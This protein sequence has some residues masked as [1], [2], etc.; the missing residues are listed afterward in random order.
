MEEINMFDY[1]LYARHELRRCVRTRTRAMCGRTCAGACEILAEKCAGCA[2]V[3]LIFGCAMCDH[4]FSH[5]WNKI[6]IKLSENLF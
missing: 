3:R 5:F 1:Y 6:A 2:C 4:I